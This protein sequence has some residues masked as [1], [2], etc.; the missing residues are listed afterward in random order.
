MSSSCSSKDKDQGDAESM[1]ASWLVIRLAIL[2]E[3]N[4]R[5]IRSFRKLLLLLLSA[6]R[7]YYSFRETARHLTGVRSQLTRIRLK[8][9]GGGF[10]RIPFDHPLS[11]D[12][13]ND[14]NN[15]Q[16]STR[17]VRKI[18]GADNEG[19]RCQLGLS[20]KRWRRLIVEIDR[21]SSYFERGFDEDGARIRIQR[22]NENLIFNNR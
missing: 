21:D 19:V 6:S 9:R 5:C 16:C 11:S 1:H 8:E 3:S 7:K 22:L 13:I 20:V 18:S 4:S 14:P 2:L 17:W 10:E 12:R 15:R